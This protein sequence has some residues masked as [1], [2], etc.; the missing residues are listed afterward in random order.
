MSVSYERGTPVHVVR[1][2]TLRIRSFI[3]TTMLE[4]ARSKKKY[5]LDN[6]DSTR[7]KTDLGTP[8]I[9]AVLSTI[10]SEDNSFQI[11]EHIAL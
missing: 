8:L 6:L 1:I 11:I 7:W 10:R 9:P 3:C 5:D 2:P 4:R